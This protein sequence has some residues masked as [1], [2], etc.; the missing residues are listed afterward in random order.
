M[1]MKI[2]SSLYT[3]RNSQEKSWLDPVRYYI[4]LDAKAVNS[5]FLS[6]ISEARTRA[7]A[8]VSCSMQA[9]QVW[10]VSGRLNK[11]SPAA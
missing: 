4:F 8:Q 6:G 11:R 1:V 10:K 7:K 3:N 2:S 9:E 5:M